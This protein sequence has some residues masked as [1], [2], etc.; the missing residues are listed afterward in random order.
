M[1]FWTLRV[2]AYCDAAVS[3]SSRRLLM[4]D[5]LRLLAWGGGFSAGLFLDS[6]MQEHMEGADRQFMIALCTFS[7]FLASFVLAVMSNTGKRELSTVRDGDAARK[8]KE[9]LAW[10]LSDQLLM[11]VSAL[12]AAASGLVWL[13]CVSAGQRSALLTATAIAFGVLALVN[14]L[15][16]P[17]Q[18]WELQSTALDDE[19]KRAIDRLNKEVDEMFK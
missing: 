14:A 19:H 11:V 18:I 7:T 16:L 3:P 6:S 17:V 13:A 9:R 12:A 10:L 5:V 4:W 15:R 1:G 8:M 2:T